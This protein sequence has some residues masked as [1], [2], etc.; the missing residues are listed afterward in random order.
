M[1]ICKCGY[2]TENRQS[3]SA[4]CGRCEIHLGR[5]PID[6]FGESRVWNK[7]ATRK[8]DPRIDAICKKR[9]LNLEDILSNKVPCQSNR[10]KWKLIDAGYKEHKC[11]NCGL[12][13]WLGNP[14]PIELHHVDGDNSN[15][16]LDN[17]KIICPNCHT[18]TDNY[19]WKGARNDK[20]SS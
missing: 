16:K 8:T 15:N 3:Y 6:P 17:L 20:K 12:S 10:L 4:H 13:E 19:R 18:L 11:E 1:Y 2:Q 9:E 14:I 5:K 7:G